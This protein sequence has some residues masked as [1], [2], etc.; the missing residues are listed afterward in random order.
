MRRILLLL[1]L[2]TLLS[3][4]C[5]AEPA[6]SARSEQLPVRVYY[7][8][9][10]RV[11]GQA[12]LRTALDLAGFT[13]VTDPAQAQ[14]FVLDG[15]APDLEGVAARLDAGAGLVLFLNPGLPAGAAQTLLGL[16]ALALEPRQ[17]S[18]SLTDVKG[19]QDPVLQQIIWNSAP[20]VREREA[21]SLSGQAAGP[22]LEPL[23]KGFED[24]STVLG[25][26]RQGRAFVL[27]AFLDGANPQL[28]E[29]A[30]FNYL[31]YHLV[32]RASGQ[33]P[34]S[35]ADYPASPVPHARDRIIMVI[36]MA[37]LL[38]TALGVFW[39]VRRYSLA[40]PEALD[41]L[42][43]SRAEF[44]SRQAHTGWE[45]IGFHR[46]LGGFMLAL[47]LGLVL[48]VP[49][50]IYQN[51]ILPV[52]IL[53]SAQ[54]LGIWGRVV[55]FF[56]FLW[57]FFDMGTSAAFIKFFS[58]YRVHDPRKAIQYG[59]V[60][61]WW[62][63]IS[64]AAQV[65]GIIVLA[66][67]FLP[68]SVYA[69]YTWSVIIHT[70]I[71]IPGFYQVMRHSLMS[72]QRFDFAQIL[73]LALPAIF[74]M[75]AQ[76]VLV[77]LMV[78]WGRS[79]PVFG[80][81]MGGLLGMGLAA[82][83]AEALTFGLGLLLY[84]RLGYNA[85]LLFLAHFD[86]ATVKNAFNFGKFEMLGSVAWA[87]GQ[88][89]EIVIT[90]SRLVNYTEIWGNWV[91]A[92]NFIYGFSVIQTLNDNLMPSISEAISHT[93][94]SLSQYYAAMDYKWGGL[95]SAFIGSVLLAVADRFIL[96][97]SGPEFSRAATYAVPLIIWGAIQFP[98]WVGDTVQLGSNRP[99][100]KMSFIAGEQIVRVSLAWL[101]VERF[102][103][104][105]LIFA[106]FV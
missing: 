65:A 21:I 78:A 63:A 56:N 80:P 71:Q 12:G 42:V 38:A 98:S 74:P 32:V 31:V 90:Q 97:A 14:V 76:P 26:A 85:R 83:A 105:A 4:A 87:G 28:Q 57:L 69:L 17:D 88:A 72:W 9:P 53:P 19:K 3:S 79:N 30:Y 7:A 94:R 55:Q 59:Q 61:V 29:W 1:A 8:G 36:L 66:G 51:L 15:V 96:G 48:F 100:L 20:Q 70:L 46:P 106:Y 27:A 43:A 52:F 92:Q 81:A 68:R 24:G 75:I 101:L 23:V 40:H 37:V 103:I 93:R 54:A 50:I 95:I 13:L 5:S 77:M 22:G 39:V 82:Y 34:L 18:L 99:Y 44:E 47:M 2:I 49:L 60:F 91:L 11:A 35:F 58:Q 6:P 41:E 16:P 102:Q 73:D 104:N 25:V 33:V 84:R 10:P 45:T 89:M 86:W 64:G 62:Q 67:A